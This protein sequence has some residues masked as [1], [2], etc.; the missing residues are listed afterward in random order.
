ML[1]R[2]ELEGVARRIAHYATLRPLSRAETASYVD[3]RCTVAGATSQLFDQGAQDAIYEIG[4]G[5]LRATDRLALKALELAAA[6]DEDVADHMR[7]VEARRLL[8]P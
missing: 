6:K 1:R 2:P 8:W 3:H 7:I 5:N 4:R